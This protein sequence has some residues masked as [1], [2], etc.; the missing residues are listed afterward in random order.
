MVCIL[1]GIQDIQYMY[2]P[3]IPVL[4]VFRPQYAWTNIR[5]LH[6]TASFLKVLALTRPKGIGGA[7]YKMRSRGS[8]TQFTYESQALRS[9]IIRRSWSTVRAFTSWYDMTTWNHR[10]LI[11]IVR[12]V[13]CGFLRFLVFVCNISETSRHLAAICIRSAHIICAWVCPGGSWN[14]G[15]TLLGN[16]NATRTF[17]SQGF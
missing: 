11:T 4:R 17:S 3:A 2:W 10:K 14:L 8:T 15:L 16:N 13:C 5:I 9:W 6:G 12:M 7:L 1:V